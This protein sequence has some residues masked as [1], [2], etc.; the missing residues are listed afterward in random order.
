[1]IRVHDNF[2]MSLSLLKGIKADCLAG[3]LTPKEDLMNLVKPKLGVK[4]GRQPWFK[5]RSIK[6]CMDMGRERM[7]CE[8]KVDG[9]YCQ[10]HIDVSKGTSRQRIQIFSK[11]GKDSTE[12]RVNLHGL[13]LLLSVHLSIL[14]LR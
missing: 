2:S 9:E 5:A 8:K 4:V 6:H 3:R 7:S 14:I 13:V 10:I 1:M 11:S 12:D